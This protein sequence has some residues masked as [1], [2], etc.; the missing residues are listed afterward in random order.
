VLR[1]L[2]PAGRL[3]WQA[4]RLSPPLVRRSLGTG[5]AVNAVTLGLLGGY[6]AGGPLFLPF[7]AIAAAPMLWTCMM[8]E[9]LGHGLHNAGA[10][11][12]LQDWHVQ[13]R[14]VLADLR[15]WPAQTRRD[16]RAAWH[17][18]DAD[19]RDQHRR[20]TALRQPLAVYRSR[21]RNNVLAA[22]FGLAAAL[23]T[24]AAAASRPSTGPA[25][26]LGLFALLM[27]YICVRMAVMKAIATPE[28]LILNGPLWKA[29]VRW[30]RVAK[31][32]GDDPD[33]NIGLIPVRAPTLLL[34]NGQRFKIKQAAYYGLSTRSVSHHQNTPIHHIVAELE[35]I[36]RT[37]TPPPDSAFVDRA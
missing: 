4:L 26:G 2:V 13:V 28:G 29:I 7:L 16:L 11:H 3:P 30:D 34:T 12:F 14:D 22:A 25:I 35:S 17:E 36:R 19:H 18:A 37:Y 31:V 9:M 32:I 23:A 10:R 21:L 15:Q 33:N 5:L 6:A 20:Q 27:L 8:G 1:T 24:I